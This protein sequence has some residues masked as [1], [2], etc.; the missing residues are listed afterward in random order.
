MIYSAVFYFKIVNL[1]TDVCKTF[2]NRKREI[3]RY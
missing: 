2:C 1:Q 3:R